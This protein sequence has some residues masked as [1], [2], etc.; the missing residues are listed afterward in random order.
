MGSL[1]KRYGVQVA[2]ISVAAIWGATFVVVGDA[3]ALY[4]MYGFLWWRFALA[5]VAFLLVF[6]R[7][8]KRL[9][10]ATVRRGALAG[11][12]LSAGYIFQTWALDGDTATSAARCAFITGLYVVL[13]PIVQAAILK[14]RPRG[15]TL[16]GV[17]IAVGGLFVLS[18]VLGGG[19]VG[20]VFG[21]TLALICAVAYTA[22]MVLLGSTGSRYDAL[23]LTFVQL[24]TVAVISGAISLV[25]EGPSFPSDPSVIRAIVITALFASTFAYVV[26]NWAQ[27]KVQPSRVALI[28][29]TEP[30]FGGLF[31]WTA[32]GIFPPFEL[33]GA[34]MM[35]AGMVIS[36]VVAAR[37]PSDETTFEPALEGMP[38]IEENADRSD[39]E[40]VGGVSLDTA[41]EPATEASNA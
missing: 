24:A 23:A 5:T 18:G 26:Q 1:F 33:V 8:L 14:R 2:L 34:G 16:I 31:G 40:M 20:W 36:E 15:A 39:V 3:I 6:P 7:V 29:V 10:V 19:G 21:D 12:L 9:D 41:L 27:Q 17:A 35:L 25:L 28:L 30:A 13:V 38:L 4:P 37:R 32:R 11:T 22:H